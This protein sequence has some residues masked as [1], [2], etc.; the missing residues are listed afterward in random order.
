VS[1]RIPNVPTLHCAAANWPRWAARLP[2]PAELWRRE[3]GEAVTDHR[4]SWVRRIPTSGGP[5]FAKTYAYTT[6]ADRLRDFGHRTAPW[7]TPRAVR[8]FEAL[9][10][11][12]AHDFAAPQPLAVFTW[13]RFGFLAR[14]TLVTEAFAGVAADELLPRL[15]TAERIEVATAIGELVRALHA[16]GFRDRNLD[17][18]NLLVALTPTGCRVA[19]IDSPRFILRRPGRDDALARAD[20]ARLLPQLAAFHIAEA[21]RV[22]RA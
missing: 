13:R 22:P 15:G 8:E 21:A 4:S 17:L 12:R 2:A 18:R 1:T 9:T 16:R 6:W 3:Q 20:W 5:V 19:K 7:A 14:A 11:L 10:W